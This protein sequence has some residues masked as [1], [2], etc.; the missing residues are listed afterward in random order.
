MGRNDA[1]FGRVRAMVADLAEKAVAL[2]A[3]FRARGLDADAGKVGLLSRR[4]ANVT[5]LAD[6]LGSNTPAKDGANLTKIDAEWNILRRLTDG[7]N[8]PIAVRQDLLD[9]KEELQLLEDYLFKLRG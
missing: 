9:F 5:A 4:I 8:A 2:A 7:L 1:N 6:K 3:A